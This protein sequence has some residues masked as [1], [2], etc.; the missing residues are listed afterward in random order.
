METEVVIKEAIVDT[1]CAQM[2]VMMDESIPVQMKSVRM[3][4]HPDMILDVLNL[5][6][7]AS[8]QVVVTEKQTITGALTTE[9]GGGGLGV[10]TPLKREMVLQ[11]TKHSMILNLKEN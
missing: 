6:G 4:G 9:E 5:T 10:K 1:A 7:G 3:K 11:R 8:N 2:T